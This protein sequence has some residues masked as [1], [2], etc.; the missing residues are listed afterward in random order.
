MPFIPSVIHAAK[1]ISTW[2]IKKSQDVSPR[3]KDKSAKLSDK[4]SMEILKG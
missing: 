4:V 1:S 2:G 3:V